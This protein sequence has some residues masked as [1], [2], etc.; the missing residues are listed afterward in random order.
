MEKILGKITYAEF[1]TVRDY[2]FLMGL[3]LIFKLADSTS[4]SSGITYMVNVSPSCNWKTCTR[5]EGL[6]KIIDQVHEILKN[7]KVNHVS[8]L[9]GKPV[10]VTIEHNTF[11]DFRILTEVFCKKRKE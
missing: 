5:E 1:G 8:E 4:I 6:V 3:E 10:E 2:P 11:K 9:I 7:A